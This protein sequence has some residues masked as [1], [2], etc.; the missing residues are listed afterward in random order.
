VR[1][2]ADHPYTFGFVTE[3]ARMLGAHRRI[4]D[5]FFPL[6]EQF[7][8]VPGSLDRHER[9]FVLVVSAY[10]KTCFY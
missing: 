6:L 5:S 4:G 7:M 8:Y 3:M 2:I 10:A 1:R 9:E